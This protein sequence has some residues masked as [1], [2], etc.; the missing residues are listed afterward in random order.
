M[1]EPLLRQ[2]EML[3]LLPR[4]TGKVTAAELQKSLEERG[5]RVSQRTVQRDLLELSRIFP[6]A[7]DEPRK[8]LGWHWQRD[9]PAFD[10][11]GMDLHTAL[12]FRLAADHLAH[13]L[14]AATR[15]YL[16]PHLQ[17][18]RAVLARSG[19]GPMAAWPENVMAIPSGLPLE[20]PR[21][22]A[23]VLEA[24]HDG[25]F[26]RRCLEVRYRSRGAR[27]AKTLVLHPLGLVYKDA[28]AYLVATAWT[29]DDV[30]QYALHRMVSATLTEE[31]CRLPAGFDL[32]AYVRQERA[33]EFRFGESTLPL[34]AALEPELALKLGETPL[35]PDQQL[36]ALPDGRVRLAAQVADTL[37]LRLWLQSHG[38]YVEVLE[39]AEL[40]AELAAELRRAAARY[41]P[42]PTA[43]RIAAVPG[44]P[45]HGV[46][47]GG[48]GPAPAVGA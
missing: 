38:G 39:P 23:E 15:A 45:G 6:I 21:I 30:R 28:V 19:S 3:R 9:A 10:I 14:P 13:L 2:W 48:D 41:G 33:F 36:S 46:P 4:S 35:T 27:A 24:V 32:A 37:Q 22:G 40:R 31:E 17:T 12:A 47:P 16:E 26:R 25:L 42:V 11:P 34:V 7:N 18:A 1:S 43:E 29:Y 20:P 44:Q 5:F 8:P